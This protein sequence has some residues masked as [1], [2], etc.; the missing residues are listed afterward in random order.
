[1]QVNIFKGDRASD[2]AT[3]LK[4]SLGATMLR[5]SGSK[6]SGRKESCVVNWGCT[7]DEAVRLAGVAEAAGR[8][9]LNNPVA[10]GRAV[11]KQQFFTH[12]QENLPDFTIPW[13]TDLNI[14]WTMVANG[15]RMFA[16]TVL[17][18]HSGKGIQL[19][20]SA[21]DSEIQSIRTMR[22]SGLFPVVVYGGTSNNELERARL[23]TQGISGK[24]IEYRIHVFDGEVIL[25][26]CKRRRPGYEDN[27]NYQSI[28]RN[29]DAGWIYAVNDL[30]IDGDS[31]DS[32]K[33]AAVNT[34]TSL[35]L[36]FGAVDIVWQA[37]TRRA[38]VLEVNT[39]PGLDDEGS[40]LAAYTT[41]IKSI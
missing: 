29:V 20:V 36:D 17:T 31:L 5:S 30:N 4:N 37:S 9:F 28:V 27:P 16:R 12:M 22:D 3:T 13:T 34:V 1:M 23:F 24:R 2:G 32:A 39:A 6:Y 18:G 41:A 25:S 19:M 8:R 14:A 15:S 35:G 40:A 7:S 10:I 11:N 21:A 38:F 33:M 26:Q